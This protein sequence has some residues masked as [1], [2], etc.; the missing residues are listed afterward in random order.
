MELAGWRCVP[1]KRRQMKLFAREGDVTPFFLL[2]GIAGRNW[3]S[4]VIEGGIGFIHRPFERQWAAIAQDAQHD[5]LTAFLHAA[6]LR[7]LRGLS[8]LDPDEP[9]ETQVHVWCEAVVALLNSLPGTHAE[10]SLAHQEK[11]LLAGAPLEHFLLMHRVHP[12][13]AAREMGFLKFL[14]GVSSSAE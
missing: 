6:N 7:E 5:G 2:A 14:E 9:I 8:Y 4:Y 10:L 12:D 13:R 3:G 1:Y 11:R